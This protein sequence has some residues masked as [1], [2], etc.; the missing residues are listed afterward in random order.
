MLCWK[1]V[2]TL[3]H[4]WYNDSC[5]V[6]LTRRRVVEMDG[7]PVQAQEPDWLSLQRLLDELWLRH[8]LLRLC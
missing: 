7:V 8:V 4:C 1:D 3:I 5:C 2:V 6:Q